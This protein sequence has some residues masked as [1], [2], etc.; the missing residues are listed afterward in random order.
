MMSTLHR[1]TI[2]DRGILFPKATQDDVLSVSLGA[3]C[4][5]DTFYAEEMQKVIKQ[6]DAYKI[7]SALK[8]RRKGRRV[9]YLEK[10]LGYPESV[11]SWINNCSTVPSTKYCSPI[12]PSSCKC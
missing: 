8:K 2:S 11:N 7:Q 9:Q 6:D 10:W 3:I 1:N 4:K 12:R 5:I